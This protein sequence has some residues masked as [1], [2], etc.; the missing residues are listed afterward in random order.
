MI[1]FFASISFNLFSLDLWLRVASKNTKIF[2]DVF[3]VVPTDKVKTMAE[4]AEYEKKIPMAE[5]MP[6]TA[7]E[8]LQQLQVEIS[9]KLLA[10]K[11]PNLKFRYRGIWYCCLC[12]SWKMKI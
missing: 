8:R 11:K 1:T 3:L 6:Q 4:C 10:L 7:R 12:D 2:D 9:W 5:F